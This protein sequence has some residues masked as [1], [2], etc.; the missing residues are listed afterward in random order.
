MSGVDEY[1]HHL[2][3][4]VVGVVADAVDER[5]GLAVAF[6]VPFDR[7]EIEDERHLDLHSRR[8]QNTASGRHLAVR[9]FRQFLAREPVNDACNCIA[10][11]PV[12]TGK[13]SLY[14]ES[15]QR[16][17]INFH[18]ISLILWVGDSFISGMSRT[19]PFVHPPCFVAAAHRRA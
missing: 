15:G 9:R 17:Q 13:C 4:G 16:L 3:R 6:A 1:L 12:E 18:T 14:T 2:V 11:R 5:L 19:R 10:S 8:T 7:R